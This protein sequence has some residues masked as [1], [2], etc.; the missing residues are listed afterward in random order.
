MDFS[1]DRVSFRERSQKQELDEIFDLAK[2]SIKV[3]GRHRR[4]LSW[5]TY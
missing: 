2:Y 4:L 1:W 3:S 5:L